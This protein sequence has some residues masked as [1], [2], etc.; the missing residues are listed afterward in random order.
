MY[1]PSEIWCSKRFFIYH[2]LKIWLQI[3]CVQSTRWKLLL[4]FSTGFVQIILRDLGGI[5]H[6]TPLRDRQSFISAL[7][8][9][10]FVLQNYLGTGKILLK[11]EAEYESGDEKKIE[12]KKENRNKIIII[13]INNKKSPNRN[14]L[15]HNGREPCRAFLENS[16]RRRLTWSLRN[17]GIS[18]MACWNSTGRLFIYLS[19]SDRCCLGLWTVKKLVIETDKH[20]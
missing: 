3:Y 19:A 16:I 20:E 7:F 5:P 8:T 12:R 1:L 4:S 9:S 2:R 11:D 15:Q 17:S 6:W 18:C 14:I 13:I 10:L